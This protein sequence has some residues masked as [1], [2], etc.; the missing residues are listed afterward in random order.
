[1]SENKKRATEN[2]NKFVR[3]TAEYMNGHREI[4]LQCFLALW[5]FVLGTY[6]LSEIG[7]PILFNDEV[8]YWSN[9]AF[10]MGMDWTSVTGK[11][12]YYSYGYSLLLIPVRILGNFF[13]WRWDSLYHAAV[14][15]NV[16]FLIMSFIL[17]LKI[18]ARYLP[19]MNCWIRSFACFA[20]FTYASDIV[21]AHI[22]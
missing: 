17:A 3:R 6:R 8:G 12:G 21:Y 19:E 9:S 18:A 10:F 14:V 7:Q 5:I 4:I 2:L 15:M 13:G 11:I 1:M 22:T 20:I 16:G